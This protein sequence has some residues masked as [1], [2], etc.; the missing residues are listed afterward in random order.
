MP[1]LAQ[2]TIVSV[3]FYTARVVWLF[4]IKM[5]SETKERFVWSFMAV[6]IKNTETSKKK[7]EKPLMR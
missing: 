4:H 7:G 2:S 3:C 5:S 6:K 1:S